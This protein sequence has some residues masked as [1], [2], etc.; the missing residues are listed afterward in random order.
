MYYSFSLA[1]ETNINNSTFSSFSIWILLKEARI[2]FGLR[3]YTIKRLHAVS[4]EIL[5]SSRV[6]H[7]SLSITRA[8][9]MEIHKKKR[10]T[11]Y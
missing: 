7:L 9:M 2:C 8:P 6:Y 11:N 5:I 10:I 1:F 4:R 3:R